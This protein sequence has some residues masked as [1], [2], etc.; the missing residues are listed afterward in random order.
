MSRIAARIGAAVAEPAPRLAVG[1]GRSAPAPSDQPVT[2]G[3]WTF[4]I[5]EYV[6][7]GAASELVANAVWS[8]APIRDGM[9]FVAVR[10]TATNNSARTETIQ[11]GDFGVTGDR[12]LLYRFV[13]VQPPDPVL[14]SAVEPGASL[15]GWIVAAAEAG[16]GNLCLV[17][18]S[19]TI[20]GNWADVVIA[21]DAGARIADATERLRDP[22]QAGA[23]ITAPAALG[24][25][26]ATEDWAVTVH[27][28]IEGQDVY[29]LFP[30]ADYRTTA[31][32]DTDQAG[33]P[34]WI[35]LEVTISSNRT[36]GDLNHFPATAFIPVD[37]ADS[38]F[39]EALLLTPPNPNVV[40]GYY[41]GGTREGWM[42]I[43]MPVGYSL[44]LVRFRPSSVSGETRYI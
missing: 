29:N 8:N 44:D 24:E 40:G 26:V 1:P 2:A 20:G 23:A 12:G 33:L 17:Y 3:P 32:G 5:H 9:Q 14:H 25:T 37:G 4:V 18:D 10:M 27:R 30:A 38:Q 35:G 36:G 41:P 43:A 22:N 16:E 28:A 19:L 11:N 31:L 42:L 34:Y 13:D 15:E 7:G 39:L 21:L 6:A